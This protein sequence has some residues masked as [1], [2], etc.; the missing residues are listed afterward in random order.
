[1]G[2]APCPIEPFRCPDWN[3]IL[4]L[5]SGHLALLPRIGVLYNVQE[6]PVEWMG[7]SRK[8]LRDFPAEARGEAGYDLFLVQQG[9]SPRDWKPLQSVGPGAAE[10]RIQGWSGGRLEHRVVYVAR[11]PE[12]VYVLHAFQKRSRTTATR[13]L[14]TARERYR[15]MLNR[16]GKED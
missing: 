6:K 4:P 2:G 10:I 7:N 1:M 14:E 13:D 15:L 8:D 9:G 16:R 3:G 11:F 12:A 5:T